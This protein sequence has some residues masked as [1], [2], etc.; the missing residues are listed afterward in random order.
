P[1]RSLTKPVPVPADFDGDGK[2]D[3]VPTYA[4]YTIPR[5]ELFALG[6][7]GALRSIHDILETEGT[8]EVHLT[9]E[10]FVPVF[11]GRHL[12]TG[13]ATWNTLYGI[14]YVGAGG[15]GF[16]ARDPLRSENAIVDAGLGSEA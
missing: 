12:K 14:A 15:V 3:P 7:R 9:N 10:F 1:A 16:A 5:Y 2:I 8:H 13:A 11:H 4:F 6:S